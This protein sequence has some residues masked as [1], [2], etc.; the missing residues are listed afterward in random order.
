MTAASLET[1]VPVM[2]IATPMSAA[3]R[4]GASLT[5]SPV[6]ATTLPVRL[7][8]RTI[9]SLASCRS[10]MTALNT[11]RP[12][13]TTEVPISPVTSKLMIAAASRMICMKSRYWRTNAWKPDSFLA[14]A[15]RFGPCDPSRRRVSS[16]LRPR[17][18]S[19]PSS[20]ATTDTA[21]PYQPERASTLSFSSWRTDTVFLHPPGTATRRTPP[22]GP[23]PTPQPRSGIHQVDRGRCRARLPHLFQMSSRTGHPASVG[24]VCSGVHPPGMVTARLLGM[25]LSPGGLEGA[26]AHG[27]VAHG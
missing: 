9:R 27:G 8:S 22:S 23:L 5:P 2:P 10:P 11:V 17:S 12:A 13:S 7:S 15:S 4:A 24:I 25:K 26:G 16:T 20:P 1:S 14:P 18:G 21:D 19:T 3:L 6:M